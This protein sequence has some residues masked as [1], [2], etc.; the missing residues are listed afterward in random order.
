M[1][2]KPI[3][4]LP[5]DQ[6]EY[7]I[8]EI[9]LAFKTE[10]ACPPDPFVVSFF[11]DGT[12]QPK[13]LG[14]CRCREDL[15]DMEASIPNVPDDYTGEPF[16][17]G[18]SLRVTERSLADFKAKIERIL[19]SRK[20][21]KQ[22][23]KKKKMDERFLK[24]Q[25]WLKQLER[26]QRYLGLRPKA[27]KS[28]MLDTASL[29]AEQ[30]KRQEQDLGINGVPLDPLGPLDISKPAPYAFEGDPVIVCVDVEAYERDNRRITEVGVST[31]DTLDL[32]GI[33]PGK[34]GDN[35]IAHIRSRHFRIRAREHLENKEFCPG[36]AK[37]FKFGESE[38]VNLD[39]AAEAVD[40]CFE[41]PFSAPFKQKQRGYIDRA[42]LLMNPSR[43][44]PHADPRI[45]N[46]IFLGHDIRNEFEYLKILGC[47]VFSPNRGTYPIAAMKADD[48]GKGRSK[49]YSSIIEAFDTGVLYR[50][51]VKDTQNQSL[52]KMMLGLGRTVF[53]LHNAG[54]D[55]RYTL[56]AFI[57]L[58]IKARVLEGE[59]TLME[60][61][62]TKHEKLAHSVDT[63]T[64]WKDG[65][66]RRVK[67]K[68]SEQ[69]GAN[70]S[71]GWEKAMHTMTITDN[72]GKQIEVEDPWLM[73]Q[74]S[75][76]ELSQSFTSTRDEKGKWIEEA[77]GAKTIVYRDPAV[78]GGHYEVMGSADALNGGELERGRLAEPV[79]EGTCG[80]NEAVRHRGGIA[81]RD[82]ER[83]GW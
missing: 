8:Q 14:I 71:K 77:D 2:I 54:N 65:V 15:A 70:E 20:K 67:E 9:N 31:L 30:Q 25:D 83:E 3:M 56:E 10:I 46:V 38:W 34:G 47:Q 68:T 39:A 62:N 50:V 21:N 43:A 58:L 11:D 12:P 63:T 78:T 13:H 48:H 82:A 55:A 59:A 6:V 66:D 36:N 72:S 44:D 61:M 60:G 19:S 41:Y 51:L 69:D 53:Q 80:K 73:A 42:G 37:N 27:T 18:D 49:S 23:A 57:A 33:A 64:S 4:L 24:Q 26:A 76:Q 7:L 29:F 17:K 1:M 22:A 5:L 52:G 45:R 16:P 75:D 28:I 32:A 79:V 81:D 40:Q 74:E 35:W